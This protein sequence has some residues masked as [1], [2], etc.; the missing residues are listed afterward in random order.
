MFKKDPAKAEKIISNA[1]AHA[2]QIPSEYLAQLSAQMFNASLAGN[3]K[4][5][6]SDEEFAQKR[7]FIEMVRMHLPGQ[8]REVVAT[9][10]V[11]NEVKSLIDNSSTEQLTKALDTGRLGVDVS[12]R[13]ARA[14]KL[15]PGLKEDQLKD[16]QKRFEKYGFNLNEEED[17]YLSDYFIRNVLY[18]NGYMG[19]EIGEH[20]LPERFIPKDNPH[21][22]HYDRMHYEIDRE[23]GPFKGSKS[24]VS[25]GFSLLKNLLLTSGGQEIKATLGRYNEARMALAQAQASG[26]EDEIIRWNEELR[27]INE[28]LFNVDP[29]LL[30]HMRA[31]NMGE[32]TVTRF[33]SLEKQISGN[34]ALSDNEKRQL[35]SIWRNRIFGLS[36]NDLDHTIA[37]S[38]GRA[39]FAE[40]MLPTE[41][42]NGG[43]QKELAWSQLIR[44]T[45]TDVAANNPGMLLEE[46][47]KE[48]LD[49][50]LDQFGLGQ[51]DRNNISGT[52]REIMK[53]RLAQVQ[54]QYGDAAYSMLNRY[55]IARGNPSW[56]GDD[57]TENLYGALFGKGSV[58]S[59]FA[60]KDQYGNTGL[61]VVQSG[62]LVGQTWYDAKHDQWIT[63][64]RVVGA[65]TEKAEQTAQATERQAESTQEIANSENNIVSQKEE[66]A[67]LAEKVADA[68]ERTAEAV[69][70]KAQATQEV[71]D[72]KKQEVKA[73]EEAAAAGGSDGSGGKKG[74]KPP[75][76]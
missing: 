11:R 60:R 30:K 57:F 35:S 36:P 73:A 2:D 27:K 12:K 9:E 40:D 61:S 72:A 1:F 41:G 7:A 68:E 22:D 53:E 16:L 45:M 76:G 63:D 58:P 18:E 55:M 59:N 4:R 25:K 33:Q 19:K 74:K 50:V 43:Q 28:D 47:V 52:D 64:N 54:E 8:G 44:G 29:E 69:E 75:L 71:V 65:P 32:E 21:E 23:E 10:K 37:R 66:E 51:Y 13:L 49:Q 15:F 26:N 39:F 56:L 62:G 31:E 38:F 46:Q 14:Q 5:G 17:K 67:E 48:V 70:K 3:T 6:L 20:L 42:L 24:K 34:K